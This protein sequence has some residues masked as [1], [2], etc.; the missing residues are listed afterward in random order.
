MSDTTLPTCLGLEP[1][2]TD[3]TGK[4][5]I[6]EALKAGTDFKINHFGY[7]WD[8]LPVN[9]EQILEQPECKQLK[10]RYRK[11]RSHTVINVADLK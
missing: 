3:Y 8:G 1:H 2:L 7:R 10:V 6:I 9:L 11:L 4:Q 5:Q